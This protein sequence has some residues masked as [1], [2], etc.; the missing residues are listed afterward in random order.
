MHRLNLKV[1]K[2]VLCLSMERFMICFKT[3][4]NTHHN[5]NQY[6][7]RFAQNLKFKR[8]Y[9][10]VFHFDYYIRISRIFWRY[11][12]FILFENNLTIGLC[13]FENHLYFVYMRMAYSFFYSTI[14]STIISM[15][16]E[17]IF[18]ANYFNSI[19]KIYFL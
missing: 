5:N 16:M 9:S 3:E 8:I 14:I 7:P 15:S 18:N 12:N 10:Q 6:A 1:Y 4:E 11:Y 19:K 2:K 17:L 13:G